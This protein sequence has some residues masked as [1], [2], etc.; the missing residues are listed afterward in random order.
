MFATG[1]LVAAEGPRD[2]TISKDIADAFH[3]LAAMECVGDVLGNCCVPWSL[4]CHKP[5]GREH[6]IL[7]H[8][9]GKCKPPPRPLRPP[10]PLAN[11]A[12]TRAGLRRFVM[13]P[14]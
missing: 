11:D 13:V 12:S 1:G 8:R 10:L 9:P 14:I 5:P 7:Q 6:L 4:G 3:L 2:T